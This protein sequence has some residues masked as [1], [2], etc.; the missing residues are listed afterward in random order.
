MRKNLDATCPAFGIATRRARSDT[1]RS[2]RRSRDTQER[3]FSRPPD[4]PD[5]R[6]SPTPACTTGTFKRVPPSGDSRKNFEADA[7]DAVKHQHTKRGSV[8][9]GGFFG[10]NRAWLSY[11]DAQLRSSSSLSGA[12]CCCAGRCRRRRGPGDD[13]IQHVAAEAGVARTAPPARCQPDPRSNPA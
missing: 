4:I 11:R 9:S 1:A 13:H 2:T 12:R 3:P 10:R 7:R 6:N 8:G 5:V